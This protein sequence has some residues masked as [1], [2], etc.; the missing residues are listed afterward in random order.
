MRG[1]AIVIA[2]VALALP[3]STGAARADRQPGLYE[4][5]TIVN[6][7]GGPPQPP[8]VSTRCVTPAEA[9]DPAAEM[10]QSMQRQSQCSFTRKDLTGSHFVADMV[11]TGEQ[12]SMSHVD[13]MFSDA[14]SRGT[15]TVVMRSPQRPQPV[16][17]T[18]T[19]TMNMSS[20]RKGPCP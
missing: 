19:M 2:G 14:G 13:I 1:G 15:I 20:V 16:T 4:V 7:A 8:R 9:R 17:M 3:L 5:T 12:Q 10:S 11:C 18:M 6:F